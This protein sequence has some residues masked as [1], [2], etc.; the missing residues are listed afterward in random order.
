MKTIQ[1]LP[2]DKIY[3]ILPDEVRQNRKLLSFKNGV[4]VA[5]GVSSYLFKQMKLASN[6]FILEDYRMGMIVRGSLHGFINLCE[7]RMQAGTIV[8]ITPGTIVEPIDVSDD[9]LLEGVGL[10]ADKFILA[11]GGRLPELFNGQIR[12][13]RVMVSESEASMID[14]MMR[15]LHDVMEENAPDGVTYSVVS[16]LTHYYDMLFRSHSPSPAPSHTRELFRRFLRLV[17]LHGST[18]HRLQFYAD[19]LCITPRYLGTV[20]LDMSGVG[21]KEW[22]DR[23]VIAK[24][25]VLLRHTDRQTSQIADELNFPNASFFCK[26]FKRITGMSPMQYRKGQDG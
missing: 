8:F 11:H 3:S 19:E 23:A 2:L 7:H 22:I 24:A 16:A 18:E 6:P 26:Y 14:R 17:N 12:D 5:V 9:F 20:V 21:A 4:G 13:G 10:S 15:L 1:K 25:K